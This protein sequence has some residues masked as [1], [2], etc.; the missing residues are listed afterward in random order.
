MLTVAKDY[1]TLISTF[2]NIFSRR[3]WG[4]VHVLLP[5]RQRG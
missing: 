5:G 2:E 1:C 4:H 3:V